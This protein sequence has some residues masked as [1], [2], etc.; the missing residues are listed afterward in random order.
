[1]RGL[2]ARLDL[3]GVRE[4]LGSTG[5]AGRVEAEA[6][7]SPAISSAPS[8]EPCDLPVFLLGRRRPG[9]DRAQHDDRRLVGDPAARLDGR[10]QG[11]DVLDVASRRRRGAAPVDGAH[12]PAVGRVAGRDVLAE[13]DVGVVL[14]GDVV[15]VVDD[16]RLPSSWCPASAQASWVTPSMMSPSEAS[17]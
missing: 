7:F 9:D 11:V 3:A 10:Q 17:T 13:R 6:A 5:K 8:A 4:H 15:L 12:V 14:D 16:V 2:A 1:V